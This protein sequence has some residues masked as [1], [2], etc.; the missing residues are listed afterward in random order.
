MIPTHKGNKMSFGHTVDEKPVFIIQRPE[1]IV[2]SFNKV[3]LAKLVD[4]LDDFEEIEPDL[5][6]LREKMRSRLEVRRRRLRTDRTRDEYDSDE[7]LEQ[8][9]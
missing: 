1:H 8:D 9:R 3:M 2:I 4:I 5:F 6:T 7:D